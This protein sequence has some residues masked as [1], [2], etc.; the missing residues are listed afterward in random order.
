[1]VET[2]T[3]TKN[4]DRVTGVKIGGQQKGGKRKKRSVKQKRASL[5]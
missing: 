4:Y 2:D 1:M 3:Q 5:F